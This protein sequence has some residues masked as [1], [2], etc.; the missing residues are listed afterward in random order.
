[1]AR[2][3]E[4]PHL[5]V[6]AFDDGPFSRRRRYAPLAGVV[7]GLPS[8]VER[9]A[10]GRVRVDGNDAT[11]AVL[12]LWRAAGFGDGPRAI[13]LD[14][15]SVGGF[16]VLD[17]DRLHRATGRPVVSVTRRRPDYPAIRAALRKYFPGSYRSRWARM[18]AHPLFPVRTAAGVRFAAAAGCRRSDAVRLLAR[19][20]ARG[21]WPEP[22]RL[23]RLVARAGAKP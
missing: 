12:A 5:R 3:L 11:R 16:N 13:L 15:I 22:L 20:T 19:C 1:L 21:A 17:L 8:E 6:A 14:G 7:V 23:A 10:L 4:K 18:R 9:I 2:A